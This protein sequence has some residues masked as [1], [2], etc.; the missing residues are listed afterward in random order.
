M[1]NYKDGTVSFDRIT[2]LG[3]DFVSGCHKDDLAVYNYAFDVRP[4]IS[5]VGNKKKNTPENYGY[6]WEGFFNMMING[7]RIRLHPV[8]NDHGLIEME[9][10][11]ELLKEKM[12]FFTK[13]LR[14]RRKVNAKKDMYDKQWL[15]KNDTPYSGYVHSTIQKDGGGNLAVAD[16]HKTIHW[17]VESFL[18]SK[19]KTIFDENY[20]K[21][22]KSIEEFARGLGKACKAIQELRKFFTRELDSHQG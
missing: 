17:W 12:L 21:S 10:K 5:G 9:Q 19:G 4:Y 14:A 22:L 16:C 8:L 3:K 18:D 11:L 13:E 7:T 6:R 15:N 2:V 20:D 1:E